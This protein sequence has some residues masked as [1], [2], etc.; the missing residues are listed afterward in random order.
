M[1]VIVG[2]F[3]QPAFAS[4][5]TLWTEYC[6]DRGLDVEAL[7]TLKG[8]LLSRDQLVKVIGNHA[9]VNGCIGGFAFPA[10][11]SYPC[12]HVAA[13][14]FYAPNDPTPPVGQYARQKAPPKY[15]KSKGAPNYLFV[16]PIITDWNIPDVKY[17]LI[18]VE[19]QLNALRLA[20]QGFHAVGL[21]GVD[22]W[23]VGDKHSQPLPELQQLVQSDR[24]QNVI[25]MFDADAAGKPEVQVALGKLMRELMQMRPNRSNTLFT[26][27]PPYSKSGNKQGPDDFLNSVGLDEFNKYLLV[28]KRAWEDHPQLQIARWATERFI[29]DEYAGEF[30]DTSSRISIK[31]DHL[32][33]TLLTRGTFV[34]LDKGRPGTFNHKMLLT[35]PN[36][37]VAS[38]GR[39]YNPATDDEF[40]RDENKTYIN[41]HNPA[42]LPQAIKGDV[43]IAYEMLAS[44]CRDDRS[45]I[46]KILCIAARHAQYP[47]LVPKYGIILVGEQRAGKSNFAKLIGTSLSRRFHNARADLSSSF[48]DYWR[49]Y[50]CKE[51]AEYDPKMDEEWLKDLIT[52]EHYIVNGKN[53][54]PYEE[55]NYTLNIFTANGLKS[56]IQEGDKRFVIGGYA[57]GDNQRL[58]LEFERW[59]NGPGPSY[60]R[61]HLLYDIDCSGYE[62]LDT[63]TIVKGNVVEASKSFKASVK[64]LVMAQLEEIDGLE[65]VPNAI[66]SEILKEYNVNAISF[67]KEHAQTFRKPAI[68]QV[69]VNGYPYRFR[70]FK[71]YPKWA[72]ATDPALYVEQFNLA[73]KLL[74]NQKF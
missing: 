45:A 17:D 53:K 50:A 2:G 70:A 6:A 27:I 19:G 72:T 1:P 39:R 35:D 9:Y 20:Q 64:D 49:G 63:W 48:N 10:S 56:K 51:W 55:T 5:L 44:I 38:G 18:V 40:F 46:Q 21:S 31:A 25:V 23:R 66:L 57:L 65:C 68:E 16:P 30:W 71:N 34:T 60:F 8:E 29:Y 47:A 7:T 69:K 13:R 61:Y 58:G 33:R 28:E 4:L 59:V 54:Q 15:L 67:N 52:A 12:E 3:N 32:D 11:G 36:L 24:V 43:S 41:K 22:N 74:R 62:D 73:Q 42:D 14:V 37:R 26:C